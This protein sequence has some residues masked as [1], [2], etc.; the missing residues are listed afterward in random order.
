MT[1]EVTRADWLA[2][3][4]MGVGA[5]EVSAILGVNDYLSCYALW[6]DKSGLLPILDLESEAAHFGQVL[7]PIVASE[8]ERRN[9]CA[10]RD[11][12]RYSL[13]TNPLYPR[14]FAT[15]DREIVDLVRGPGALECKAPGWRQAIHWEEEPP[16]AY[17]VQV[18]A[19]LAV[20]GWQWGVLA[21]ILGGQRFVQYE[22]ARNDDLILEIGIAVA[23]FW[24][25]VEANDPPPVDG[26]ISTASVLKRLYPADLGTEIVLDDETV[27]SVQRWKELTATQRQLESEVRTQRNLIVSAMGDAARGRLPTGEV[28]QLRLEKRSPE[29]CK[30]CGAE[31][32]PGWESRVPRLLKARR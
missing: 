19:Q 7:E 5:S 32:R 25:R 13:L 23:D 28:L 21:A 1:T 14:L 15:L 9:A 18:Q 12:G 4:R 11:L 26:S 29:Q 8:Y 22:V 31:V 20:T 24:R 2:R 16:L 3:R 17:V 30:G 27:G 10:V 6:A